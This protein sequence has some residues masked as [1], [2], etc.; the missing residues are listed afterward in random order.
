MEAEKD[1]SGRG[2]GDNGGDPEDSNTNKRSPEGVLTSAK[3]TKRDHDDPKATTGEDTK[4]GEEDPESSKTDSGAADSSNL[5]SK[6]KA[7]LAK[8]KVFEL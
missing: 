8:K 6:R 2:L 7:L 1:S 5:A 4:E 3:R